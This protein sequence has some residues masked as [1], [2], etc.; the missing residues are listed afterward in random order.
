MT[1][2]DYDDRDLQNAYYEEYIFSVEVTNL[3]VYNFRGELMHAEINYP[4]SW[5][6][7]KLAYASAVLFL[8]LGDDMTPHGYAILG[9][10]AFVTRNMGGKVVQGRKT[11][12]TSDIPNDAVLAAV[13]LIVQRIMPSDRQSAE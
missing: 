8:N 2:V 9:D 7:K 4:G 5:H 3:F 1:P 6:D 10:S 11:N 13:D 12:E